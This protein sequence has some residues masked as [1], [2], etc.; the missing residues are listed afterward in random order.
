MLTLTCQ[1]CEHEWDYTGQSQYYAT[2][3]CCKSSVKVEDESSKDG[4]KHSGTPDGA[5]ESTLTVEIAT[6]DVVREMEVAEAVEDLHER[7]TSHGAAQESLRQRVD[8]H[9]DQLEERGD[10]IAEV[11]TVLKELIEAM[12][13]AVDYDTLE[14]DGETDVGVS[15]V[16]EAAQEVEVDG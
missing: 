15:A 10:E 9:A 16:A 11:A 13:G 8:D 12:G 14:I 1:R 6:G 2:C 5:E 3:P 7:T 4:S